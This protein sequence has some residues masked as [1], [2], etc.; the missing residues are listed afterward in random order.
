MTKKRAMEAQVQLEVDRSRLEWVWLKVKVKLY[1][2]KSR[3]E[4]IMAKKSIRKP[5]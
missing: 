4:H 3:I 1:A 5:K 2:D